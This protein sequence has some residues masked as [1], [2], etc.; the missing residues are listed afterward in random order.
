MPA[1]FQRVNESEPASSMMTNTMVGVVGALSA[2]YPDSVNI[3][4]P[5]QVLL[6]Y[7]TRNTM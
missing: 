5:A 2:F 4:D 3:L 7:C 6:M 1:G